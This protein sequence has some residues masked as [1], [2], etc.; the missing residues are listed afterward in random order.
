MRHILQ[1][2]LKTVHIVYMLPNRN[3]HISSFCAAN[4]HGIQVFLF[5]DEAGGGDLWLEQAFVSIYF[6]T[7]RGICVCENADFF[8]SQ[9]Y[10]I[11]FPR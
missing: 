11:L 3:N 5:L 6:V 4:V 1:I 8:T 7:S 2:W 10:S 9:L